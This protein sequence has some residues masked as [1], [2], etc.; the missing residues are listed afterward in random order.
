MDNFVKFLLKLTQPTRNINEFKKK[1]ITAKDLQVDM[2]ER[3]RER[4]G[5]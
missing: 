5:G 1:Q 3:E 2:I 4:E